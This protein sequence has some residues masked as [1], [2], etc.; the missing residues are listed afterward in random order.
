MHQNMTRMTQGHLWSSFILLSVLFIHFSTGTLRCCLGG[1]TYYITFLKYANSWIP[2]TSG[3]GVSHKGLWSKLNMMQTLIQR[4][5][6]LECLTSQ[7][8]IWTNID[9]II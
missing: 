2:N 4:M 8:L 9:Y 3:P 6:I 5:D 1:V 7:N